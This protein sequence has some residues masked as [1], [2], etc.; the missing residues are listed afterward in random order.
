M[1]RLSVFIVAFA[2]LL[3]SSCNNVSSPDKKGVD[4]TVK[5]AKPLPG[6]AIQYDSAKRYI[7]LTWDDSPQPPGT[8]NCKAVFDAQQVKATFFAVGFNQ[9]WPIIVSVMVL[10]INTANSMRLAIL[11]ALCMIF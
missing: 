1:F 9:V 8:V 4:T 7:F 6:T 3:L 11:I 5:A 2:G 10:M